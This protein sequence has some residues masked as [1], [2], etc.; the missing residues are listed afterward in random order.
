MTIAI[1]RAGLV[2]CWSR[3]TDVRFITQEVS[4]IRVKSR[5]GAKPLGGNHW[6]SGL[7]IF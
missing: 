6:E 2:R 5:C 1:A 3:L 7:S 4:W